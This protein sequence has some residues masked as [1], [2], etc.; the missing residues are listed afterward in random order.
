MYNMP[1]IT[2]YRAKHIN[3]IIKEKYKILTLQLMYPKQKNSHYFL[4]TMKI[5]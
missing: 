1:Y 5:T 2:S 4:S 3:K